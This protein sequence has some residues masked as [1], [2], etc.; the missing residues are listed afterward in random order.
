MSQKILSGSQHLAEKEIL[1]LHIRTLTTDSLTR[2]NMIA[3]STTEI[4]RVVTDP[5]QLAIRLMKNVN[6]FRVAENTS[7]TGSFSH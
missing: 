3:G 6:G 5:F 2:T 7:C 1:R 4:I